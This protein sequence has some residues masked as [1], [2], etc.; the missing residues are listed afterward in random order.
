M[1]THKKLDKRI[2]E[3]RKQLK[4]LRAQK[5]KG[6]VRYDE[7]TNR[8][9]FTWREDGKLKYKYFG[10]GTYGMKKAKRLAEEYRA[11]I[12]PPKEE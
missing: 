6:C 5:P 8:W 3:L 1:G 7:G 4:V 12:F 11:V 10:V 2:A 9:S